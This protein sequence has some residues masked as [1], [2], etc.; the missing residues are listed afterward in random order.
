M[1]NAAEPYDLVTVLLRLQN[2]EGM[3]HEIGRHSADDLRVASTT[4][5]G[6]TGFLRKMLASLRSR[7]SAG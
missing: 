6:R 5:T 1:D 4:N 3:V 2:L 7:R